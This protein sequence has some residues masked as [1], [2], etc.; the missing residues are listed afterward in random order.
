VTDERL[1]SALARLLP[2]GHSVE[3]LAER[4]DHI[5]AHAAHASGG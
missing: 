5:V 4:R 2:G 1:A 3:L